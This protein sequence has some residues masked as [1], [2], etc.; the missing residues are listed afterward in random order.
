VITRNITVFLLSCQ[1]LS[2]IAQE[3]NTPSLSAR[4]DTPKKPRVVVIHDPEA[5]EAFVPR[6][7]IIEQMVNRGITNLTAK[8]TVLEAWR[9]LV[10]TQDI[11]GI[12]VYSAP[13]RNTGTHPTVVAAVI[14]GLMSVGVAPA[15]IIVWD[16]NM[17][18]LRLAGFMELSERFGVRIASSSSAGYD[19]KVFYDAPLLGQLVW[20]D[21]EFGKQGDGVGRKSFFSKLVTREMTKIINITP[22]LNHNLAGVAGNLYG[23]S[24]GTVDNVLR[25]ETDGDRLATAVPE[26]YA[27]N[28]II[29]HV[30]VNIVDALVCQ[31]EG[32]AVGMLHYSSTLNELRFSFDPVALDVLSLQDLNRLRSAAPNSN[33][34]TNKLELYQNAALMELGVADL[35]HIDIENVP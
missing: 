33:A 21:S 35:R 26:I 3:S 17:I 28:P 29:D 10:S 31:Y 16:K 12:K 11:V 18:D 30:A 24:I 1:F 25:F 13:G 20:G 19:D 32:G 7:D 15:R 14:K 27:Q 8:G 23:L 9:S 5:T 4:S 6:P 2:L 34:T 22:L